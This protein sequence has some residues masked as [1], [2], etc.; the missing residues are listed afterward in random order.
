MTDSMTEIKKT[1]RFVFSLPIGLLCYGDVDILTVINN[2]V[3]LCII[4]ALLGSNPDKQ[5]PKLNTQKQ[6]YGEE[7]KQW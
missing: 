2:T 7:G 1:S 3:S 4:L 6:G 5:L